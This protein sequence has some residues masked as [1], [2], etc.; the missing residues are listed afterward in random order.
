[1]TYGP[2][3]GPGSYGGA[4]G[5]PGFPGGIPGPGYGM[6]A[7]PPPRSY[8][9]ISATV[10]RPGAES[11]YAETLASYP[12]VMATPT[13]PRPSSTY[14]ASYHQLPQDRFYQFRM[15]LQSPEGQYY[16]RWE[17]EARSLLDVIEPFNAR[18]AAGWMEAEAGLLRPIVGY[19]GAF[20]G[21]TR[22]LLTHS[23]LNPMARNSLFIGH[24]DPQNPIPYDVLAGR[25]PERSEVQRTLD[26][27][28]DFWRDRF[29]IELGLAWRTSWGPQDL[30]PLYIAGYLRQII[31]AVTDRLWA[32]SELPEIPALPQFAPRVRA[33]PESMADLVDEMTERCG[34]ERVP[35]HELPAPYTAP[36]YPQ[37]MPPA[38][39]RWAR[40][41]FQ[42]GRAVAVGGRSDWAEAVALEV[43]A[44]QQPMAK[45]QRFDGSIA[46]FAINEILGIR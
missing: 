17:N 28:D 41:T 6:P 25:L 9:E 23:D 21:N 36:S 4:P 5:A 2:P 32:E 10:P 3:S 46:W 44:G 15:W 16:K 11:R 37:Q 19:L 22:Q 27:Y 43:I 13:I 31:D 7:V 34:G 12:M 42:L 38:R 26:E 45:V 18:W 8:A 33:V 1:M 40:S 39:P 29:D 14:D 30:D 35:S 20:D 24:S